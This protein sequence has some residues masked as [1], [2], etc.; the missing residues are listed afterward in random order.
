MSDDINKRMK[1]FHDQIQTSTQINV[2]MAYEEDGKEWPGY[3]HLRTE[4]MVEN[5][6]LP[7]IELTFIHGMIVDEISWVLNAVNSWRLLMKD[8]G[9]EDYG[10]DEENVINLGDE[11]YFRIG[12]GND[13]RLRIISK[14]DDVEWCSGCQRAH[15]PH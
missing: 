1:K 2:C 3:F 9:V 15:L 10:P 8:D 6:D 14:T 4:G 11:L 7:D 5:H 12:E 13:G